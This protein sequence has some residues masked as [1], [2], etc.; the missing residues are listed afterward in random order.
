MPLE[1]GRALAAPAAIQEIQR[2]MSYRVLSDARLNGFDNRLAEDGQQLADNGYRA[3][4]HRLRRRRGSRDAADTRASSLIRRG[5]RR[6]RRRFAA[7][8]LGASA[9]TRWPRDL[10][11]RAMGKATPA[12]RQGQSQ[13]ADEHHA[14]QHASHCRNGNAH[15]CCVSSQLRGLFRRAVRNTLRPLRASM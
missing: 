10:R 12:R 3:G 4:L 14:L 5:R 9:T 8:A 6:G 7:M 15:A 1:R 2:G 13:A 11:R